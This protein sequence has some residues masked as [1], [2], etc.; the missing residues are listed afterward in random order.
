MPTTQDDA[1]DFDLPLG[2]FT[3]FQRTRKTQ[4]ALPWWGPSRKADAAAYPELRSQLYQGDILLP[5]DEGRSG[6]IAKK[7]LWS[8]GII[9]YRFAPGNFS[10]YQKKS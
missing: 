1:Q 7:Y 2:G 9:P 10:K 8:N 6:V 3:P 5:Y 4:G